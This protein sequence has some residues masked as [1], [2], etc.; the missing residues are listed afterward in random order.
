MQAQLL[1]VQYCQGTQEFERTW[2]LNSSAVRTAMQLSLHSDMAGAR[3]SPLQREVR[4]RTW[5]ACFMIDGYQHPTRFS[6]IL[7]RANKGRRSLSVTLGCYP[8][9]TNEQL[10]LDLPVENS[11]EALDKITEVSTTSA[12]TVFKVSDD[13][14]LFTSTM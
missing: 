5:F 12:S 4:K 9:V 2:R 11:L 14:C 13:I 3:L 8:S 6:L 1:M 10:C 7:H